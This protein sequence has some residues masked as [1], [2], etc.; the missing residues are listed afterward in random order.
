MKKRFIVLV[1]AAVMVLQLIPFAASAVGVVGGKC[2]DDAYWTLDT[3][4]GVMEISGKGAMWEFKSASDYPWIDYWK[5]IYSVKIQNG[6]TGIGKLAFASCTYLKS[7]TIPESVKS[8][9]IVALGSPHLTEITVDSKN[10][11]FTCVDNV[12][13]NNNMTELVAYARGKSD[14]NYVIPDGVKT[15]LPYAFD[16]ITMLSSITIP[17]SVTTFYSGNMDSCYNLTEIKVDGA[18]PYYASLDGVLL[19]KGCK[20]LLI[21][22]A[23]KT[24]AEYVIPD[25]VTKI[26]RMAFYDN[27]YLRRVT[28]PAGVESL[29]GGAFYYCP[30]LI[31]V[32][33]K[34]DAPVLLGDF[35]F[36]KNDPEFKISYY[37]NKSGWTSPTW[38][39]YHTEMKKAD[40][41]EK[42]ADVPANAWYAADVQFVY[43]LD[44]MLG[45]ADGRFGS[46]DN[47]QR[48]QIIDILYRYESKPD[49][50]GIV[51]P[52]TDLTQSWYADGIKWAYENGIY[53]E[54]LVDGAK[55]GPGDEI[56]REELAA[57]LYNYQLYRG[58]IPADTEDRVFADIGEVSDWAKGAVERMGT[59]GII[60]GYDDGR[61]GYADKAQRSQYAAMLRR[62][63]TAV[64]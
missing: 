5:D 53:V 11:Y 39:G 22:P 60:A 61:F 18:S 4:T 52:F 10:Q 7:V 1:L 50:S 23:G 45:Y 59:Q 26:G 13:F 49:V 36:D 34:G 20:E 2:G 32:V 8:I 40:V 47:V 3:G 51:T 46:A 35:S 58:E 28:V 27:K 12:L 6:V 63:I 9:G 24:G 42:F 31:S 21:Y 16:N 33:F 15:V 43:D 25:S 37:E 55:F 19:D 30:D 48:A 44:L 38:N 41:S 17:K 29:G 57:I 64:D 62:F 14:E 56:T 54:E